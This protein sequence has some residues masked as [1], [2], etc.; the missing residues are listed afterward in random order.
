[1]AALLSALEFVALPPEGAAWAGDARRRRIEA[2]RTKP[3][4]ADALIAAVAH[5]LGA[6][7]VTR[8]A[9]D[10][11]AFDVPVLGYGLPGG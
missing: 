2:G 10:F 11:E 6:T 3:G 7:V 8:N 1:M 4:T 9:K 5:A